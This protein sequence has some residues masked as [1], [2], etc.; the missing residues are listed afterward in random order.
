MQT[1]GTAKHLLLKFTTKSVASGIYDIICQFCTVKGMV[2]ESEVLKT[3][4]SASSNFSLPMNSNGRKRPKSAQVSKKESFLIMQ[5]DTIVKMSSIL[6][7]QRIPEGARIRLEKHFLPTGNSKKPNLLSR[8]LL[9]IETLKKN[10]SE[11]S[12]SAENHMD[13][14]LYSQNLSFLAKIERDKNKLEKKVA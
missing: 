14:Y 13:S 7:C 2:V 11:E 12:H 4:S 3:Q 10:A 6:Q 1:V 9:K 5:Q 8:K